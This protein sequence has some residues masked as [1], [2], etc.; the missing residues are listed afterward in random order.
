MSGANKATY[1]PRSEIVRLSERRQE[2]EKDLQNLEQQILNY[3]ASYL[4]ES[5]HGNV[6][7]GWNLHRGADKDNSDIKE[8]DRLFSLASVTSPLEVNKQ[9]AHKKR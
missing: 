3:E 4:K 1:N 2:L 7:H 5:P 9:R 8:S 6:I